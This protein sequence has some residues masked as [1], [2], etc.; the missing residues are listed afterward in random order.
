MPLPTKDTVVTYPDGAITST[1]T[2]LHIEPVGEERLALIL[3]VTAFHPIDTAW[4][5]QP[6]DRGTLSGPQGSQ[7]IVDAI[8][9]GI[10]D[11]ELHLGADLPVRVGTQ[12]WTFVVAH[13]IEGPPPGV[14]D[15]VRVDVDKRHR[16]ELSIAH[17]A[18]HLA[19]LALDAALADAWTKSAPKD[20][21]GSAAFDALA[22][23][24]SR[25]H[26]CRST[27]TY[28]I[29]KSLRRKGFTPAALDDPAQVADRVNAQLAEWIAAG[30]AVRVERAENDLSARRTWV[31]ELPSG[32]TDIPCGG[33]HVRDI[34]ELGDVTITLTTQE[35]DGGLELHMET[36]ATA[37]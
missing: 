8:T 20:A 16:A 26:P 13:I 27:D 19:A 29:G 30:G 25:L 33:T 22:I 11:G 35:I 14:G 21:L 32:T 17:T 37:T 24:R 12:G 5:D 7:P 23:Q 28:R 15:S 36:V 6:A 2:V 31:S 10:H 9:G 4:P 34:A 18:C 3:D 1:G